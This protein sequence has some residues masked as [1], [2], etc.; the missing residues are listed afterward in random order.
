M[1]VT[2]ICTMFPPY[3]SE[4]LPVSL[5]PDTDFLFRLFFASICCYII[6]IA[7][8]PST[9]LS[10]K[11]THNISHVSLSLP[12]ISVECIPPRLFHSQQWQLVTLTILSHQS[13]YKTAI[14]LSLVV[15]H[16]RLFSHE[17]VNIGPTVLEISRLC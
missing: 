15:R 13:N 2:F 12:L 11:Y 8:C 7:M 6:R 5:M 3:I 17:S 14:C 1:S 10:H 4:C 9:Y 16:I